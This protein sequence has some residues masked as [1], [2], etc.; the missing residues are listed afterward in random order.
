MLKRFLSIITLLMCCCLI[1]V[2]ACNESE[3]NSD[4]KNPPVGDVE[5]DEGV[6]RNLYLC[7]GDTYDFTAMGMKNVEK[8][9]GAS[10]TVK[11]GTIKAV[12]KGSSKIRVEDGGEKVTYRVR[13]YPTADE[14]GG[15]FPLDKGMFS[16]KK[17]IVFGDSITDGHMGSVTGMYDDTYFSLLCRYLGADSDPT[18]L[19]NSNFARSATTITYGLRQ[20]AG[21]SG[22]ERVSKETTFKDGGTVERDPYPNI[23]SAD[24]CIIFYGTNDFTENVYK[25]SSNNSNLND[26][27]V[28]AKSARSIAGGAYYMITRIREVNPDIKILVLPPLYRR[29]EGNHLVY[30]DGKNDV[31]NS[32]T[33]EKLSEYGEVLERVCGENGAKFIN[34][35]PLFNYE[36]FGNVNSAYTDDGLHPNKAGHQKMFEYIKEH[37]N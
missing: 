27:P 2:C 21:I 35:Y 10:V 20:S 13:I 29:E 31:L 4:G 33:G 26:Y 34:W 14:L 24:L 12:A 36:N 23:Q 3:G 18:D 32:T 28:N 19:C 37:C 9:G 6:L 5:E 25:D 8:T 1:F 11:D 30:T 22:V 17:V 7:V 16:G 15:S